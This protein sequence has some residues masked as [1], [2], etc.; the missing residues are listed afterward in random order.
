MSWAGTE[1]PLTGSRKFHSRRLQGNP[2][3]SPVSRPTQE[4]KAI[5]KNGENPWDSQRTVPCVNKITVDIHHTPVMQRVSKLVDGYQ[6]ECT[7]QG[8]RGRWSIPCPVVYPPRMTPQSPLV[9][10]PALP[11]PKVKGAK[12]RSSTPQPWKT[13]KPPPQPRFSKNNRIPVVQPEDGLPRQK[14]HPRLPSRTVPSS[15]TV[16]RLRGPNQNAPRFTNSVPPRQN[17]VKTSPHKNL[18]HSGKLTLNQWDQRVFVPK[19]PI[20]G[21]HM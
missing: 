1:N 15:R 13:R 5:K 12:G 11:W 16:P 3:H 17:L 19:E 14:D 8:D 21:V 18:C 10:D 2:H 20:H 9:G 7:M 4:T 6:P